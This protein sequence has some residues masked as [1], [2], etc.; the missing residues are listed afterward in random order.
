MKKLIFAVLFI[1]LA[2]N[3]KSNVWNACSFF[4]G[5]QYDSES[6][7]VGRL[8]HSQKHGLLDEA[9]LLGWVHS[10]PTNPNKYVYQ[11]EACFYDY[12]FDSYEAYYSQSGGQ[13]YLYGLICRITGLKGNAALQTLWW[14]VSILLLWYSYCLSIGCKDAGVGRPLFLS[15]LQLAFHNGLLPLVEICSGY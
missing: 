12:P 7:V 5:F 8:L 2:L 11:Y 9:G 15:L 6:L 14:L 3:F 1:F 10:V 13:A 4:E